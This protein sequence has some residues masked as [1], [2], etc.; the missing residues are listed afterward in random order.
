[1]KFRAKMFH[2]AEYDSCKYE[3]SAFQ[4]QNCSDFRTSDSDKDGEE[5]ISGDEVCDESCI[6]N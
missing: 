3:V 2:S 4:K 6:P 5:H 1:M